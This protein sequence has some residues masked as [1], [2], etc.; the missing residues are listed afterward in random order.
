VSIGPGVGVGVVT[1]PRP[2]NSP[3]QGSVGVG[4]VVVLPRPLTVRVKL[5]V[6]APG[7]KVVSPKP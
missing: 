4:G 5:P 3:T 6:I 2:L 7:L 1:S